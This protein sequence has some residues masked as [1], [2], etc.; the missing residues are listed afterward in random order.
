MLLPFTKRGR[1]WEPISLDLRRLLKLGINDSL[2]PWLLAPKVGLRVVDGTAVI[3]ALDGV[4][5]AH[6]CGDGRDC[7]S[8]GVYPT[9]LPDGTHVCIL[10]PHHSHRRNKITLMEEIVHMHRGHRPSGLAFNEDTVR[11]RRYDADQEDEA[12][13]VGAAALLPWLPLFRKVNAGIAAS[14]LSQEYDV[15][16]ALIVYRIKITG[17]YNVYRARQRQKV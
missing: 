14:Q 16:E 17:A 10:N 7:W 15:T 13:G 6:L 9:P 12:Y 11:I 1:E 8:G 5:R 3:A 2:D 4:H